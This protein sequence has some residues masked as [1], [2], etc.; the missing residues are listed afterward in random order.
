VRKLEEEAETKD[1]T[2]YNICELLNEAHEKLQEAE[3]ALIT[4]NGFLQEV[5]LWG[6]SVAVDEIQRTVRHQRKRLEHW[7]DE[8]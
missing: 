8:V 7:R 6:H 5:E 2:F 1:E 3:G 4:A